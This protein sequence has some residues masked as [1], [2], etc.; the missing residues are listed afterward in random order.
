M[1]YAQETRPLGQLQASY[2]PDSIAVSYSHEKNAI[3]QDQ[4]L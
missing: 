4:S 1:S 2:F 3:A